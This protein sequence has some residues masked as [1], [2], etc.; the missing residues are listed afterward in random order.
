MI[1][2]IKIRRDLHKLPEL[3]FKEYNTQKYILDILKNFKC[4]IHKINTGLL[5]HFSFNKNKSIVYRCDMDALKIKEANDVYYKSQNNNMHA[6]G[7][8]AH[9]AIALG[10]CDYFNNKKD[11]PYDIGILFQ[12]S[13]ESYG[14][15]KSILDSNIL[16]RINTKYIVGLHLFP[17][18][19]KG[20]LFTNEIIFSSAREVNIEV[21][22]DEV[23]IA[24]S[25]N[26]VNASLIGSKLLIKSLKLSNKNNLINFGII[27]S[28]N[29]RNSLSPS[30]ILK[31]TIRS[32]CDDKIILNKLNKLINRLQKK[33][34]TKISCDTSMFL[35][36]VK[37]DLHLINESKKLINITHLKTTFLQGEDFSL[38]TNK[39]PCLFLLLGVGDTSLLHTP[40]F[41]FDDSILPNAVKQI[42]PLLEMD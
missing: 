16:D 11:N 21:Y 17:K 8:D 20:K 33:Y 15:S 31:G 36:S 28:G 19:E 27:Q 29:N 37:S 5:A 13:E 24:N 25:K 32:K 22:G 6:C 42:I 3:G 38:Y 23:H 18:L 4:K 41:N 1:D 40:S 35:P 7:H 26:K 12:P 34:H 10:L 2:V 30:Y 9:M 14:G 39:Y